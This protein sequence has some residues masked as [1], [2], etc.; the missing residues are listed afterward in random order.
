MRKKWLHCLSLSSLFTTS[1]LALERCSDDTG[2]GFC[3]SQNTC[4]LLTREADS[5]RRN[6]AVSGCLPSDLGAYNATCCDDGLTGCGVGYTCGPGNTCLA[7]PEN[8]DPLVQKLPRYQLCH[9]PDVQFIY[10][11]G[12]KNHVKPAYYASMGDL[13]TPSSR[14]AIVRAITFVIHGAG[15]N[16]DDYFCTMFSAAQKQVVYRPEQVLVVALRFAARSDETFSLHNGGEPMRWDDGSWR[17]GGESFNNVSSFQVLDSM[18]SFVS[19]KTEFPYLEQIKIIGH[20][21]GGQF[22]Q[23]WALLTNVWT[24]YPK[25]R[26]IVVNPSSFAYLTPLRKVHEE[27]TMPDTA[28]CPDYNDWE[29]G[30]YTSDSPPFYVRRALNQWS[31]QALTERFSHRDVVYLAGDRDICDVPGMSR[32]GWCYSHGL[33]T[34][35]MDLLE[36]KNRLERHMNYFESLTRLV[37]VTTHKRDLVPGVGHDHSLI[38]HSDNAMQYLFDQHHHHQLGISDA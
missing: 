20:S 35:C 9:A 15:R 13:E 1:L 2:G 19:N 31:I 5:R 32:N 8:T 24:E 38:F 7:K 17:Y 18:V 21:A 27:W 6:H 4:C 10:G 22:V 29:W 36:G 34:L 12:P 16:A 33:E 11:F 37:N 25:L 28:K 14:H 26:A 3:P 23:R 30:L